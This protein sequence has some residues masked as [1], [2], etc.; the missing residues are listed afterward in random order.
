MIFVI[1]IVKGI[2]LGC[3][4]II[5]GISIGT[6][7]LMLDVYEEVINGFS[8]M[9][10]IKQWN[11]HTIIRLCTFFIPL[12]MGI[13]IAM[14]TLAAILTFLLHTYP[15]FIHL[16]F[17]GIIIGSLPY[18]YKAHIKEHMS[19]KSIPFILIGVVIIFLFAFS[20]NSFKDIVSTSTISISASSI[21]L[22]LLFGIISAACGLIPGV[23]G[24]FVL[25]ILGYYTTY[26]T[27][28]KD[29]IIPLLIP[30]LIGNI[31]GFI[32]ISLVLKTLLSKHPAQSYAV[33]FGLILASM[34]AIFPWDTIQSI[35]SNNSISHITLNIIIA[36]LCMF[37]G[38]GLSHICMK[39]TTKKQTKN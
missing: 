11:K 4:A 26:L 31:V 21:F 25:F 5:P 12:A 39:K 38:I 18:I 2:I 7:A 9:I 10:H 27:I 1:L 3:T 17:I 36:L 22:A 16:G 35:V 8:I 14:I 34:I 13:V 29:I 23:S 28:I 30:L 19:I 15:T 6:M 33:I 24:S 32:L 20:D 37:F